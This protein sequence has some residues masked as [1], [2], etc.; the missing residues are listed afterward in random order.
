MPPN[1]KTKAIEA[2]EFDIS[3]QRANGKRK[4]GTNTR[5]IA[6]VWAKDAET[7]LRLSYPHQRTH[8]RR[9][10][11]ISFSQCVKRH[12][13]ASN[14]ST[15]VGLLASME[16]VEYKFGNC[17]QLILNH[18]IGCWVSDVTWNVRTYLAENSA[19][20]SLF[21]TKNREFVTEPKV[22]DSIPSVCNCFSC[23]R[24]PLWRNGF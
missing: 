1:R 10:S 8:R 19:A 21:C 22:R 24:C 3:K 23:V 4:I 2:V 17:V 13:I 11:N 15:A 16:I 6:F 12:F 18:T 20:F 14:W 9:I 5:K 7:R